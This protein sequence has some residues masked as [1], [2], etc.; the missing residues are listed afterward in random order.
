[1]CRDSYEDFIAQ[2][3]VEQ[4]AWRSRRRPLS[5][6]LVGL[7][8]AVAAVVVGVVLQVNPAVL[9]GACAV[10]AFAALVVVITAW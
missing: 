5:L 4:P 3:Q 9:L 10:L 6:A 1:M 2:S 8:V 7:S